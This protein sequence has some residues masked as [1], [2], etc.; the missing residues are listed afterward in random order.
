MQAFAAGSAAGL[1]IAVAVADH[2][3]LRQVEIKV[4]GCFSQHAGFGFAALTGDFQFRNLTREALVRVM[5]TV[6]YFVKIGFFAAE[7]RFHLLMDVLD[8]RF[9]YKSLG[10]HRLVGNDNA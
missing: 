4:R 2:P 1:R 9:G 6:I 3:A 7:Q 5:R 8:F 10:N